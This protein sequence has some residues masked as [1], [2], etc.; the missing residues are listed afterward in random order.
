SVD[1]WDVRHGSDTSAEHGASEALHAMD[2]RRASPVHNYRP[3]SVP[4]LG[5]TLPRQQ[6]VVPGANI[7]T[8][9]A[10]AGAE[11]INGLFSQW[12]QANCV[13]DLRRRHGHMWHQIVLD[14]ENSEG[15]F[16]A[17][18]NLYVGSL[19]P[20]SG[21]LN[22]TVTGAERTLLVDK[23]AEYMLPRLN[24]FNNANFDPADGSPFG[25]TDVFQFSLEVVNKMR[26]TVADAALGIYGYGNHGTPVPFQI[27]G[28]YVQW[29]TAFNFTGLTND[30]AISGWGAVADAVGI[31]EYADIAAWEGWE[32]GNTRF[33]QRRYIA[34]NYGRWIGMGVTDAT[35]ESS[36]N[37]TKNLVGH[38]HAIRFF[39]NGVETYEDT[40]NDLLPKFYGD[41]ANV[42][43]LFLLWSRRG[44][45]RDELLNRRSC[46]IIDAMPDTDYRAEF[47]RYMS[48]AMLA[49]RTGQDNNTPA[50]FRDIELCGRWS[51]AMEHTGEVH[52]YAYVRRAMD[53][54]DMEPERP[55]LP[56]DMT[57][58]RPHWYR[59]PEAP[60]DADYLEQRD[61]N[62]DVFADRPSFMDEEYTAENLVLFN[63]G[64]T[65]IRAGAIEIAKG[66]G[67]IFWFVGPG[68]VTITS[69]DPD[70]FNEQLSQTFYPA[71]LHTFS[72]GSELAASCDTGLLFLEWRYQ[73]L[74]ES[75]STGNK[76]IWAPASRKGRL[77]AWSSGNLR[78][79][80]RI[81]NRPSDFATGDDPRDLFTGSMTWDDA[82]RKT[83]TNIN[84]NP[85][86]SI[87]REW[88]LMPVKLAELE[89]PSR[90]IAR[91]A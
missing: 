39:R 75:E 89:F 40:L 80:G 1:G 66:M 21:N 91:P 90:A 34:E 46:E 53:D 44:S 87:D 26:E 33:E 72:T 73:V 25:S 63:T 77:M 9:Y 59:F 36:G 62:N 58:P 20:F 41:D 85:F 69:K 51:K 11:P 16:S 5:V 79:G 43:D 56:W 48:F 18:P 27:P 15:F 35:I 14:L 83:H 24:E 76:Y 86:I 19:P 29:A 61:I 2:F 38:S 32:P 4:A 84:F 13:N 74:T 30:E 78:I 47:R 57:S 17:N 8:N 67:A 50:F 55:D 49:Q 6:F 64:R 60:T 81:I 22:P 54:S 12:R 82:T 31:R 65:S 37:W 28:I 7:F 68:T 52:H 71:G 88:M 10:F 42:A 23:C 45:L 70:R 3:A